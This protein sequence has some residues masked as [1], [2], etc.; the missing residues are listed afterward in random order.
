MQYEVMIVFLVF[1]KIDLYPTVS[2]KLYI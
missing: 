2:M 1:R